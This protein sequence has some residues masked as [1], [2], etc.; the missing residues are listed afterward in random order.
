MSTQPQIWYAH[1]KSDNVTC[2]NRDTKWLDNAT[3]PILIFETVLNWVQSD[4]N[5]VFFGTWM[6][7]LSQVN[8]KDCFFY[9][10]MWKR[11]EKYSEMCII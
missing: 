2:M 10:I 6:H 3:K 4:I 5:K 8:K 7:I 11:P 1:G 9:I